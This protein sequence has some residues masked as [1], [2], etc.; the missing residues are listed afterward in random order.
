MLLYLKLDIYLLADVFE[1]F[2]E[3]AIIEDTLDPLHY[4]SIPGVSWDSALKSMPRP[5]EL[6]SD[7]TMYNF[8]E[9]GIRGGMT[10]VNKHRVT[11]H[12]G[13]LLYID[14]NNLYGWALSQKLPCSDFEWVIEADALHS[15]INALPQMA[16]D[17]DEGFIFEVDLH[18]PP[19][20]HNKLD[21]LPPAPISECPPSTSVKKLLLHHN[22]K[23]HYI[24]HYRLLQNFMSLG[25]QVSKVHRAIKFHQDFV[26]KS[27]IDT[28]T[29]KRAASTT[30]FA[31][32]YYKL[33]NNS[34]YGKTVE[35]IRKRKNLRLCNTPKKLIT[36]ASKPTFKSSIAITE[37]LVAT[38][39]TK[40]VIVL[41]RPV[42]IGQAVLDMSKLRTYT[43]Q[44]FEL[45][46]Y[47]N[48]F[49]CDIDICA[50]DTDSFFLCCRGVNLHNQLLPA[51]LRDEALDTSNYPSS[52]QLYTDKFTSQIG[53]FKDESAGVRY[54]DWVF[55]RPKLYSML[56]E[57]DV[58]HKRAKGV[59]MSQAK[60]THAKYVQTLDEAT[61][62]YVKQRRIGSTNHQLYTYETMKKAL[63]SIDDKRCWIDGNNSLAYGHFKLQSSPSTSSP[64]PPHKRCRLSDSD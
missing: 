60:L 13:E 39:L 23:T 56:T 4:Y 43:L 41:N 45:E 14:V 20:L 19:S 44:Y 51:M 5:L 52:H 58:E 1:S 10:F 12:D 2:R 57:E 26:F 48:E 47:R 8:F 30:T 62:H 53:K 9:S 34:L 33:K 15:L 27:Y 29:V 36:Y 31:K 37:N 49:A 35:N 64:P 61:P 3:T 18:T 42:Y 21:Q 46:R 63:S 59:I 32:A 38:I 17:G 25:V 22:D 55:L 50:A 40:D 6:L 7:H 54:V 11:E 24:I 28:N 16:V